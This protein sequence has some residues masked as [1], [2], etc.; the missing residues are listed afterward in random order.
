M[1]K[2]LLPKVHKNSLDLHPGSRRTL[3][4]VRVSLYEG[5]NA[6]AKDWYTNKTCKRKRH[7]LQ[8]IYANIAQKSLR[9][10]TV[11]RTLHYSP[12]FFYFLLFNSYF[13]SLSSYFWII[14]KL[15]KQS[16]HLI[17][18]LKNGGWWAGFGIKSFNLEDGRILVSLKV[19]YI[20]CTQNAALLVFKVDERGA[21]SAE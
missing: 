19:N 6:V 11:A 17:A 7:A 9:F 13:V 1:N 14:S 21:L 3:P 20:L 16:L 2:D 5:V 12:T 4:S 15:F 18:G 10:F 8:Y